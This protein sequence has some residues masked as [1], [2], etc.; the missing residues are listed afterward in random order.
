MLQL[1]Y[2]I[3]R[4]NRN[5]DERQLTGVVKAFNTICVKGHLY[6]LTSHLTW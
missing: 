1:A 6:K 4:V 5:F 2:L 3:K